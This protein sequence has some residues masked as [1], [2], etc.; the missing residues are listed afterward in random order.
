M[1][2]IRPIRDYTPIVPPL[3]SRELVSQEDPNTGSEFGGVDGLI[4]PYPHVPTAG[5]RL[6]MIYAI[7]PMDDGSRIDGI[8]PPDLTGDF[9]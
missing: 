6:R 9:V 4:Q 3:S 8:A 5:E 1:T 2:E 7:D